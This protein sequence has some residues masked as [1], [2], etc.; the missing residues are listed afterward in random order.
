M[1]KS[2]KRNYYSKISLSNKTPEEAERII[3]LFEENKKIA[4]KI[5]SKYYKTQYW[6][7]D[8]ALQIAQMGSESPQVGTLW[9]HK[10]KKALF[11]AFQE[12]QALFR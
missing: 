10:I 6:E 4:Y 3:N 12:F 11:T 7:Y 5:A 8:E 9:G 1:I 2:D